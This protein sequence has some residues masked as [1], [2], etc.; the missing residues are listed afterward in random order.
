MNFI[1]ALRIFAISML[2]SGCGTYFNQPIKQQTAR[3]GETSSVYKDLKN[4]PLP[5]Q[6]VIV[7]VYNFKDLTGQYK[8]TENGSTFSTAIPQGATTMLL[9]ALDDSKWFTTIER[10]NI[11]NLINERNIIV[12]TRSEYEKNNS[13]AP[14]IS[15]LLFAGILLEGGVVSYDTNIVT[16]GLGA[17][18]FGIGGSTQYRQDRITVYLRAVSTKSG[19]ILKNV[20]VSKTILSQALDASLFRYINFQRLLE[21]ETGITKNE[22]TQMA[23]KEAIE[24]AVITLIL[25]GIE[26][27]LWSTKEG[28]TLNEQLVAK[29]KEE[30]EEE[31]S[32]LL[33][34]RKQTPK[35]YKNAFA[36]VGGVPTLTA[37]FSEKSMGLNAGFE[38]ARVINNN[39]DVTL[40]GSYLRLET[41]QTFSKEFINTALGLNYNI[42]PFESVSPHIFVGGGLLLDLDKR[43][44]Q[45]PRLE[46]V[47]KVYSGAGIN[48]KLSDRFTADL[49]AEYNFT[50][51]D[52]L[53]LLE[54]GKRNDFYYNFGIGVKYL[55]GDKTKIKE[56]TE[57]Q[58]PE[59]NDK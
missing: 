5:D 42:L 38:Y 57:V 20:Y 46:P 3:I 23:L 49:F 34:D 32:T 21:V 11:G 4:L 58:T 48:L 10:E 37:D 17:R 30:K 12:D 53:D 1:S 22:P 29:Y 8:N 9:K 13:N 16:G 36:L 54:N 27:K 51:T 44:N 39:I 31:E 2:F 14:N 47:P 15:P 26:A 43:F 7:G 6:P 45:T 18:Y 40:R 33:Y 28:D 56:E 41:G 52:K 55:F 50:F 25:E 35:K 19:K 24:K 59:I